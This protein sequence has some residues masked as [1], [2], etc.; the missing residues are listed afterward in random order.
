MLRNTLCLIY[1][2][3]GERFVI[4]TLGEA[5]LQG[6][7]AQ[8]V[9]LADDQLTPDQARLR[10]FLDEAQ[11]INNSRFRCWGDIF[12]DTEFCW[13]V[14]DKDHWKKLDDLARKLEAELKV[15]GLRGRSMKAK[16]VHISIDSLKSKAE[17]R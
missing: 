15:M 2:V 4:N 5:C 6:D 11:V 7:G 16:A 9:D 10:I 8:L 3:M 1:E 13:W 14:D 17:R 12:L